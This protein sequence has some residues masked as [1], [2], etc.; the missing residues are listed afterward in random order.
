M[1]GSFVDNIRLRKR[2]ESKLK[3][4]HQGNIFIRKKKWRNDNCKIL[5]TMWN[6]YLLQLIFNANGIHLQF[7]FSS[8]FDMTRLMLRL[9]KWKVQNKDW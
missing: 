5:V 4:C 3:W 7:L 1:P 8:G 6:H 2:I 9:E